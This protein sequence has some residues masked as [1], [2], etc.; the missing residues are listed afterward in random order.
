MYFIQCKVSECGWSVVLDSRWRGGS[1]GG[2]QH[3]QPIYRNQRC[4]VTW[5]NVPFSTKRRGFAFLHRHGS[6]S[7]GYLHKSDITTAV[8]GGVAVE[9]RTRRRQSCLQC[10]TFRA[11]ASVNNGE[12]FCKVLRLTCRLCLYSTLGTLSCGFESVDG[13]GELLKGAALTT[14]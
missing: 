5:V 13:D 3:N 7:Q 6:C 11:A 12:G 8:S 2:W 10:E 4:D 1:E 9:C 14:G